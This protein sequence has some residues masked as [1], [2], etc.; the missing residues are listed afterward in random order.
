LERAGLPGER[1]HRRG[2][3]RAAAGGSSARAP[4][5]GG[6]LN[7]PPSGHGPAPAAP[8]HLWVDGVRGRVGD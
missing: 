4:G 7:T 8:P 5:A 6:L 3:G 2:A 1:H